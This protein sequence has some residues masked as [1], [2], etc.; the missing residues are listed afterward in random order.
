M[1]VQV[2]WHNIPSSPYMEPVLLRELSR[3]ERHFPVDGH[4]GVRFRQEGS[5][6]RARVHAQAL[7]RDWWVTGEGENL[8]EGLN[9]A[10]DNLMRKVGEFKRFT[11]DKINKRFRRPR[12]LQPE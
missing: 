8:V 12:E 1:N 9:Q 10:I 7:G 6:Y 4:L 5:R 11:K 3:L 2:S